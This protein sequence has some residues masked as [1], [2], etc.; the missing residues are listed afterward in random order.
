MP[1][2]RLTDVISRYHLCWISLNLVSAHFLRAF[3]WPFSFRFRFILISSQFDDWTK[4]ISFDM[5][6]TDNGWHKLTSFTVF[7]FI[8]V[9][10]YYYHFHSHFDWRIILST[11]NTFINSSIGWKYLDGNYIDFGQMESN[12]RLHT[13]FLYDDTWI[14]RI[15]S[16]IFRSN[17]W[18]SF[19]WKN[20]ALKNL[21]TWQW[22]RTVMIWIKRIDV[23]SFWC[24]FCCAL[25]CG[26]KNIRALCRIYVELWYNIILRWNSSTSQKCP[27]CQIASEISLV[28]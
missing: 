1:F 12:K 11:A 5:E 10:Y 2:R 17:K 7:L 16:D 22:L 15:L 19:I 20:V 23:N 9:Y 24:A 21:A 28:S 8:F 27:Q 18:L 3:L 6:Y 25:C 4:S 14:L 13:I 26:F